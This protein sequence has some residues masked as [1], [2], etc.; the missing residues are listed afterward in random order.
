MTTYFDKYK[1]YKQKYLN[2]K[3]QK[4]GNF[5]FKN[6]ENNEY[7][8]E[9]DD[10]ICTHYG[11]T[12]TSKNPAN[13]PNAQC[14]LCE[15]NNDIYDCKDTCN[16]AQK[17]KAEI[18][19]MESTKP[20]TQKYEDGIPNVVNTSFFNAVMQAFFNM[21]L[22]MEFI[23]KN[24]KII[25]KF[26]DET[27]ITKGLSDLVNN[28]HNNSTFDKGKEQDITLVKNIVQ[29]NFSDFLNKKEWKDY[30]PEQFINKIFSELTEFFGENSFINSLFYSKF[31][32]QEYLDGINTK[33]QVPSK[34]NNNE[35]IYV[36]KYDFTNKNNITTNIADYDY[37][38]NKAT[39]FLRK[40]IE[41]KKLKNY[42]NFVA[43]KNNKLIKNVYPINGNIIQIDNSLLY[44]GG[45]SRVPP[46][47][48]NIHNYLQT[49]SNKLHNL[50]YI[51][52][53]NRTN[54]TPS[55]IAINDDDY[56]IKTFDDNALN[57]LPI[58][59]NNNFYIFKQIS[60]KTDI[61]Q[62]P[63][64]LILHYKFSTNS[65]GSFIPR[66][67]NTFMITQQNNIFENLLTFNVKVANRTYNYIMTGFI[68][69]EEKKT[70]SEVYTY[71]K[72]EKNTTTSNYDCTLYHNSTKYPNHNV[73]TGTFS[74]FG[75]N[76]NAVLYFFKRTSIN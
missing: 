45:N 18:L 1:K 47:T 34:A 6:Y 65:D 76:V 25:D 54:D 44:V 39:V 15:K 56:I 8:F 10:K 7:N 30:D 36:I 3:T 75:K 22:F 40:T 35:T 29:K 62:F 71:V 19:C 42:D 12:I 49:Q 31:T 61:I 51:D 23:I 17:A 52:F 46:L 11:K 48:E 68:V 38:T 74:Q 73:I 63:Q 2:A 58:D 66:P 21:D 27:S 4:G 14:I 37:N 13:I 64:Y 24:T 32:Q 20:N 60:V 43:R 70:N 57:S 9:G 69:N 16:D 41:F 53:K 55:N 28:V 5:T 50:N 33:I 59:N 72:I 26:A 67:A